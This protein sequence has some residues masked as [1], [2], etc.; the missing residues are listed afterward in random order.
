MGGFFKF[1]NMKI[2]I[3]KKHSHYSGVVDVTDERA[4]YLIKIG[5]AK[6]AKVKKV[7]VAK[8]AAKEPVKTAKTKV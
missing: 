2:E 1:N 8:P 3:I 4:N 6:L 7:A 5:V